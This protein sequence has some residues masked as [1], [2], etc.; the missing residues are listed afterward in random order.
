MTQSLVKTISFTEPSITE[1]ELEAI[2]FA[3]LN[4]NLGGDG[5]YCREAEAMLREITGAK[6]ALLTTSCTHAMELGMLALGI[7]PGE[8]VIL[9]SFTFTS[10]ANVIMRE[11]AVPV[12]VDIDPDTYN[13]DPAEIEAAITPR[14]RCILV[15]HYAGQGCD[16]AAINAIARKHNIPVMEDAAQCIGA[17]WAGKPLGTLS[18]IGAFRFHVT[19][20]ITAGGEGGAFVTDNTEIAHRAEI[21]REKGTNRSAFLRGEVD[22]YTWVAVGSSFVLSDMLAAFLKAQ[23]ARLDEINQKRLAIWQHYYSGTRE[24]EQKG[25]V[26][27]PVMRPQADHNAHIFALLIHH[28]KRDR[29]IAKMR[30][31]GIATP[32]HYQALHNSPFIRQRFGV[33]RELPVTDLVANTLMRLPLYAHLSESDVDYILHNL[34]QVFEELD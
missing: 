11:N 23:L 32:F 34:Y 28:N 2:R 17:N 1:A 4:K 16:M 6:Y 13:I 31:R 10:T 21:I 19:K 25:L 33:A 29:V 9:P 14:T 27:R 24:L 26:K 15:M 3:A 5:S 18:D 12:F 20:N 8:E 30:E 7:E 22:K